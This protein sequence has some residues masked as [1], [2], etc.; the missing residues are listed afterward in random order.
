MVGFNCPPPPTPLHL[1][2]QLLTYI[3]ELTK[4]LVAQGKING[5]F[6]TGLPDEDGVTL[7]TNYVNL[8]GFATLHPHL[9]L[10]PLPPHLDPSHFPSM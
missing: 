7:M 4:K 1:R 5:L 3:S 2:E 10:T 8:V 9:H 6:L